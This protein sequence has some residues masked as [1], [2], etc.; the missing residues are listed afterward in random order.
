MLFFFKKIILTALFFITLLTIANTC[1]T[2]NYKQAS[3][4]DQKEEFTSS[5]KAF[6]QLKKSGCPK[7]IYYLGKYHA[8]GF[9]INININ[10]AIY[11]Y[12]TFLNTSIKYQLRPNR[13]YSYQTMVMLYLKKKDYLMAKICLIKLLRMGECHTSIEKIFAKY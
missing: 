1:S 3:R 6:I 11:Y 13:I 8:Y 2:V 9:G 5:F 7:A 4:L 10:K 12:H